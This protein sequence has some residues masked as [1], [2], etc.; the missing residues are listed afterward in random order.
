MFGKCWRVFCFRGRNL[1]QGLHNR[2]LVD[3]STPK[4]NIYPPSP[5]IPNS[6]PTLSRPLV[7]SPPREPPFLGF[8]IKIDPPASRRPQTPPSP[9]PEQKKIKNIRNVRQGA[10]TERKK[11]HE[12]VVLTRA[13][14]K[15]VRPP[16]LARKTSWK[17]IAIAN[18]RQ[19]CPLFLGK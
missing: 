7:P 8:S 12:H 1:P 4:K 10:V 3:I 5:K 13:A 19:P 14:E 9:L 18:R 16:K 2:S 11:K 6:P 17:E 15:P